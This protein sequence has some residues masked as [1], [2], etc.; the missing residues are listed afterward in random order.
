MS[1]LNVYM[2]FSFIYQIFCLICDYL[3]TSKPNSFAWFLLF[4]RF[5]VG[6]QR[7]TR[8]FSC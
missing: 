5:K 8:L 4:L 6:T 3:A 7:K 2:D 1:D